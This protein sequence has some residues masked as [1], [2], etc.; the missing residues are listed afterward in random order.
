MADIVK[1]IYKGDE[2]AQWGGGSSSNTLHV[3][4]VRQRTGSVQAKWS[5][6]S[7]TWT[8][9]HDWFIVIAWTEYYKNWRQLND[10]TFE[11]NWAYSFP[12]TYIDNMLLDGEQTWNFT[13][14]TDRR[15]LIAVQ[16]WEFTLT[17]KVYSD[18]EWYNNPEMPT[19]TDAM[20]REFFYFG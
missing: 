6:A 16:A 3:T 8:V 2:M 12:R 10:V 5:T 14:Q 15:E 17:A 19:S 18:D 13:M 9:P 1:L 20:I 7:T 11:S 4:E